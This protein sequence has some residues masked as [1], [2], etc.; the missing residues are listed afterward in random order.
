MSLTERQMA[1]LLAVANEKCG[2]GVRS[3]LRDVVFH[4]RA[5]MKLKHPARRQGKL[6][7]EIPVPLTPSE[8]AILSRTLRRIE[9]LGLLEVNYGD[10]NIEATELGLAVA[11]WIDEHI[12]V[13][14]QDEYLLQWTRVEEG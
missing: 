11:D 9:S 3:G 1:M 14:G 6:V 4:S 13:L 12:E 7:S 8:R 2:D 10:Q 5:R